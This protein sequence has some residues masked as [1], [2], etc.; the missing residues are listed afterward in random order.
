MKNRIKASQKVSRRV[1][2][3]LLRADPTRTYAL[4]NEFTKHLEKVFGQL[5]GDVIRYLQTDNLLGLPTANSFLGRLFKGGAAV[6]A[7]AGGD[8]CGIAKGGF[9][10]GNTCA[11]GTTGTDHTKSA[12]FKTWFG[13]SK[14]VDKQGDPK[15]TSSIAGVTSVTAPKVVYHGTPNGAFT[16]FSKDHIADPQ[17]QHFGP[18]FYFTEDKA[19]AEVYSEGGHSDK[20]AGKSP[21]VM[22]FYLKSLKPFDADK[23]RLDPKHLSDAA[24]LQLRAAHVQR[25]LQEEGR[26]EAL[27][28]GRDFD[29]GRVTFSYT[30]MS[31]K[32]GAGGLGVSKTA[33]QEALIKQGYDS[34][35]VQGPGT[36]KN[37]FW[38][39]F[40]PTQV[41]STKNKG[42][43]N[44]NDPNVL[45][46]SAA[47]LRDE[48]GRF[49]ASKTKAFI[50]KSLGHAAYQSYLTVEG[51]KELTSKILAHPAVRAM[52]AP[53][54]AVAAGTKK[55]YDRIAARYGSK[56]AFKVFAAGQALSWGVFGAGAAMDT[57][58]W[59]PGAVA[60]MPFAAIAETLHQI[61]KLR[62]AT[63][64][65]EAGDMS[66]EQ[67]EEMA[68]TLVEQV[69]RLCDGVNGTTTNVFCPT[70]HGGGIDPSCGNDE[71]S[72]EGKAISLDKLFDAQERAAKKIETA[73]TRSE[74]VEI[75]KVAEKEYGDAITEVKTK[76]SQRVSEFTKTIDIPDDQR[77]V[78]ADAMS[79]V[80]LHGEDMRGTLTTHDIKELILDVKDKT[81]QLSKSSLID[82]LTPSKKNVEDD[83]LGYMNLE[84][85]NLPKHLH[86]LFIPHAEPKEGESPKDYLARLNSHSDSGYE[87]EP[88]DTVKTI[89]KDLLKDTADYILIGHLNRW[90]KFS[91]AEPTANTVYQYATNPQKL[92]LFLQWIKSQL[93]SRLRNQTEEQL[94]RNY[95]LA[96]F[97][98]GAGRAFDDFKS[99]EP[100]WDADEE[101]QKTLDTYMKGSREQFLSGAFNTPVA[102]DKVKLLASRTFTDL[103]G[104][105]EFMSTLMS[106]TL[107]D[108][109]IQGKGAKQVAADLVKNVDIG[110]ARAMM[111]ARTELIRAHSEGQLDAMESLGVEEV[112]V[113][114][115]WST[116]GFRSGKTKKGNPTPCPLCS[117]MKGVVLKLSEARGMIPR[118]PNCMCAWI[119]SNVGETAAQKKTKG[120][121]DK[122]VKASAKAGGQKDWGPE[123]VAKKRPKTLI[124]NEHLTRA[125]AANCGGKGG[126][127]GPCAI[128]RPEGVKV[129]ELRKFKVAGSDITVKMGEGDVHEVVEGPPNLKGKKIKLVTQ[130]S[131]APA[132]PKE[133][134]SPPP[135]PPPPPAAK[136]EPKRTPKM[137]SVEQAEEVF[138]SKY[139]TDV[140]KGKMTDAEFLKVANYVAGEYDR[141]SDMKAVAK[142]FKNRVPAQKLS[143]GHDMASEL[144][145]AKG[146]AAAYTYGTG[147]KLGNEA[148]N[149]T[150]PRYGG[151]TIGDDLDAQFR[152]EFGHEVYYKGLS[153]GQRKEWVAVGGK[154]VGSNTVSSYGGTNAMELFSEAFSAYTNKQYKRGG[155]PKD[156]EGFFDKYVKGPTANVF[157]ATGQGGGIDPTCSPG[158]S[159]GR[160]VVDSHDLHTADGLVAYLK[161]H[162]TVAFTPLALAK[163]HYLNPNGVL[164]GNL[165]L[166]KALVEKTD[167]RLAEVNRLFPNVSVKR[168]FVTAKHLREAGYDPETGER[169]KPDDG[170]GIPKLPPPPPPV[171]Y[172]NPLK[173]KDP[174]NPI[175]QKIV[176]DP[177]TM[178]RV[179][180]FTDHMKPFQEALEANPFHQLKR[181]TYRLRQLDK[182]D[183]GRQFHL[184]P[185]EQAEK[186]DLIS[187]IN[188]LAKSYPTEEERKN[189]EFEYSKLLSKVE[190]EG[191]NKL[192]DLLRPPSPLLILSNV[193][194]LGSKGANSVHAVKDAEEFVRAVCT[195]PSSTHMKVRIDMTNSSRADHT[196]VGLVHVITVSANPLHTQRYKRETHVHEMGHAVEDAKEGLKKFAKNFL[197]YRTEGQPK[198]LLNR[199]FS[200]SRYKSIELVKRDDFDK[201]FSSGNSTEGMYAGK[202]YAWG[203]TELISLGL[204]QLY[205]DPS[206]L[207]HHDPEYFAFL[208]H[209]LSKERI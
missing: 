29:E 15:E 103:D 31:D 207:A 42:A 62:S 79:K 121:I 63:H 64:N 135:P 77:K 104:V 151:H 107:T 89:R 80:I 24:R 56:T 160:N 41:K 193:D 120:Q 165:H 163:I 21:T 143:I 39:V 164:S 55:L 176:N 132:K 205:R 169:I 78:L 186:Q 2:D 147:I 144:G 161:K 65:T 44:P 190:F 110:K 47:Q 171:V 125:L 179:K 49:S 199:V 128:N 26:S 5:K 83:V 8:N 184:S 140:T 72:N 4:R 146:G 1:G 100:K 40:E 91:G 202:H 10:P 99:N 45:N 50:G 139:K 59:V 112:G 67:I 70:G 30:E 156:L 36:E 127:P 208:I 94:W 157:C 18:G 6:A 95:I 154:Y 174:G 155:L 82:S 51:A 7:V 68:H 149:P 106:R 76:I 46:Y 98:K 130:K 113:A 81:V 123:S 102:V 142:A 22:H 108:G 32:A 162:S 48:D 13:N 131:E 14:V 90:N 206:H 153:G 195:F 66:D 191:R 87:M 122:A 16:V 118:H 182:Y 194:M 105:S 85:D 75:L 115:E 172:A 12:E 116:S 54:R 188:H 101:K 136:E 170:R 114:V 96:G 11:K 37:R 17:S 117:P 97:K 138:S 27:K 197:T 28:A 38:I 181:A 73:K 133:A 35:T 92:D 71:L 134:V 58:V 124:G 187:R 196:L 33:I 158:E 19:A 93:R 111:I 69:Q 152:H 3:S 119:P 74:V 148:I 183:K 189:A 57:V 166:P 200:N 185:L 61:H 201:S 43:F 52:G 137:K 178:K 109:L 203:S 159:K 60:T 53:L 173:S 198:V 141:L 180:D 192:A 84:W 126:K 25:V 88:G 204:E 86:K 150:A 175:V 129:G 177:V 9:Q 168:A 209:S 34:I 145:S 20:A 23:D 167:P